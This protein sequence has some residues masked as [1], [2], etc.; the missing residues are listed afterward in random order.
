M[1]F[2]A[3]LKFFVKRFVSHSRFGRSTVIW[4]KCFLKSAEIRVFLKKFVIRCVSHPPFRSLKIIMREIINK[5]CE[6]LILLQ[7][8]CERKKS[9][10]N[11]RAD[12]QEVLPPRAW[13]HRRRMTTAAGG[14]AESMVYSK[15]V[16]FLYWVWQKKWGHS[17]QL[18]LHRFQPKPPNTNKTHEN[19]RCRMLG[20]RNAVYVSVLH[21]PIPSL[22][23]KKEK[24]SST[25]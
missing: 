24:S 6:F 16:C 18:N 13:L 25:I 14:T 5:K 12:G 20:I 10:C 11:N 17:L 15:C 1:G 22:Q 4:K 8:I 19:N 3:F 9:A 7:K 21:S 23:R 2:W